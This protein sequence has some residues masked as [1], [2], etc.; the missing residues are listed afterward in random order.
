MSLDQV[1][2]IA[3]RVYWRV[4]EELNIYDDCVIGT[5]QGSENTDLGRDLYYTIEHAIADAVGFTYGE[6]V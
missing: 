6:E 2:D 3:D 1:A 4:L 5:D